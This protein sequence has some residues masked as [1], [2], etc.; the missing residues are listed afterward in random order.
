MQLS[1]SRCSDSDFRSYKIYRSTQAG[2][3]PGNDTYISRGE[4]ESA[5]GTLR[6]ENTGLQPATTYYYILR[7]AH[8]GTTTDA[9]ATVTTTEQDVPAVTFE[10]LA[11]SCAGGVSVDGV[12][13]F[14]ITGTARRGDGSLATST[15]FKLSFENN[16]G[17]IN[18]ARFVTTNANREQILVPALT[19][20]TNN[21]GKFS[22][23]VLSSDTVSSDIQVKVGWE[24][25]QRQMRDAEAKNCDFAA[26]MSLRRFGLPNFRNEPDTGWQFN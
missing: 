18:Q 1:W 21:E 26:S 7:T 17:R 5:V 12:H 6:Y 13:D 20:T 11:R 15:E 19:V 14:S 22:I 2:F 10:G 24:N 25:P 8:G 23:K 3:T 4:A 16:R 9:S